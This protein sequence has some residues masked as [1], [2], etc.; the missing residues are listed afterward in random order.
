MYQIKHK[1]EYKHS[2]LPK[3]LSALSLVFLA[4]LAFSCHKEEPEEIDL[5]AHQL[6]ITDS[7]E[8]NPFDNKDSCWQYT[9][10]KIYILFGYD[11][12]DQELVTA[13]TNLL[14]QKYGLTSEGGLINTITY[15]DSF[16]HNGKNYIS[17]LTSM[18]TE[19]DGDLLGVIILGAPENTHIALARL[20]DYWNMKVPYPVFSLFPQDESLGMESTCDFVLDKQQTADVTGNFVSEES[21][22][23]IIKDFPDV[24]YSCIDYM[25][26]MNG[27]FKKDGSIQAHI[28][29]MLHGKKLQ[30]YLDP[31]TGLHAINHFVLY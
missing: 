18:L 27:P 1:I 14:S 5:S 31:E 22:S 19:A 9:N 30:Y 29:Q 26:M 7:S 16:K 23:Q 11:F 3:L 12:N 28:I 17:E 6:K 15:P 13:T 21:V 8:E 10:K 24:L 4:A 25:M 2:K 20:Q